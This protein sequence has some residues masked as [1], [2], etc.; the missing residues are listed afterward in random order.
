MSRIQIIELDNCEKTVFNCT[1][2]GLSLPA[3]TGI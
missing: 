1:L 2:P 3:E